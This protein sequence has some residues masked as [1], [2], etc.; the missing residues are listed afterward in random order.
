MVKFLLRERRNVVTGKY[1][2]LYRMTKSDFSTEE[3]RD[4]FEEE[5]ISRRVLL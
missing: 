2:N 3:N 5:A 1:T 4:S